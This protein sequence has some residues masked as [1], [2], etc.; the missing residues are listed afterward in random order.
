M[1]NFFFI[2]AISMASATFGQT[3]QAKTIGGNGVSFDTSSGIDADENLVVQEEPFKVFKTTSGSKYIKAISPRTGDEY[4]VWVGTETEFSFEGQPV[5]E[6]RNGSYCIYLLGGNNFPYS[7]W[8][9]V[10]E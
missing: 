3:F 8:L 2:L 5:Y 1:K 9:D 4:A 10:V 6:S 7:K